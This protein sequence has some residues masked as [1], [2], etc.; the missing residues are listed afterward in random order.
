MNK[1]K[2]RKILTIV[3]IAFVVASVIGVA[4]YY[5]MPRYK[6]ENAYYFAHYPIKLHVYYEEGVRIDMFRNVVFPYFSDVA[7]HILNADFID[8][9]EYQRFDDDGIDRYEKD[10]EEVWGPIGSVKTLKQNATENGIIDLYV[11]LLY[12]IPK[13]FTGR[14]NYDA[15]IS[16]ITNRMSAAYAL[17]VLTHEFGHATGLPHNDASPI[18]GTEDL[19]TVFSNYT[20]NYTWFTDI[21]ITLRLNFL[22]LTGLTNDTV[23]CLYKDEHFYTNAIKHGFGATIE[24]TYRHVYNSNE[25]YLFGVKHWVATKWYHNGTVKNE[26]SFIDVLGIDPTELEK[27]WLP[28]ELEY[29]ENAKT[30]NPTPPP[31]SSSDSS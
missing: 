4:I 6:D 10:Y 7:E 9:V 3:A 11:V 13:S 2:L 26:T 29:F 1:D 22:N 17:Y 23:T 5:Y 27:S 24:R 31:K 14:S 19:P 16:L 8:E 30:E 25:G 28:E 15:T 12:G 18:M 21:D 20:T